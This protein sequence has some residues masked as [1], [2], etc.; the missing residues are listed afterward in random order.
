[1]KVSLVAGMEIG[2]CGTFQQVLSRIIIFL[3]FMICSGK[4]VHIILN[5]GKELVVISNQLLSQAMYL[6]ESSQLWPQKLP[7]TPFFSSQY[8]S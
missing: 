1:M 3:T 5:F 8:K 6:G 7:V 2:S 4:F